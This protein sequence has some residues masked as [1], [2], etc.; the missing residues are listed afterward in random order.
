MCSP[1]DPVQGYIATKF[2]V[3]MLLRFSVSRRHSTGRTDRR[4]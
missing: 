1:V 3:S 2:E 4:T